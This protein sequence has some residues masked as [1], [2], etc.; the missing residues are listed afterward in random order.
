L[1][2][3]LDPRN[4]PYYWIGGEFPTTLSKEG[5]DADALKA[6]YVSLTPLSLDLTDDQALD[7]LKN[8]SWSL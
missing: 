2:K 6:G 4:R 3:R 7:K 1:V 5:T 8:W